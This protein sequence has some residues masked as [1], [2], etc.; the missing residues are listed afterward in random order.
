MYRKRPHFL[1]QPLL[2]YQQPILLPFPRQRQM[3]KDCEQ[4]NCHRV[5]FERDSVNEKKIIN[6]FRFDIYIY[7]NKKQTNLYLLA[8]GDVIVT[9][10]PINTRWPWIVPP[11]FRP[12][13]VPEEL[14]AQGLTVIRYKCSI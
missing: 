14:M 13:L 8:N 2:M 12:E 3:N 4:L 11:V 6:L 7:P 10:L 9:L 1:V 5:E